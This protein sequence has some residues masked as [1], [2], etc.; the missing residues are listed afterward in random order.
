MF[1][2]RFTDYCLCGGT[3]LITG[4]WQGSH[5]FLFLYSSFPRATYQELILRNELKEVGGLGYKNVS[6][7]FELLWRI[8]TKC[9]E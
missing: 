7:F 9:A 2:P 5:H 3:P 4:M 1:S 6:Q 8:I